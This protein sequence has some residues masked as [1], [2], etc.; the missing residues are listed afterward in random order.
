M[1]WGG[2]QAMTIGGLL[3]GMT[4]PN[5]LSDEWQHPHVLHPPH[6]LPPPSRTKCMRRRLSYC[7]TRWSRK[8]RAVTTARGG[9]GGG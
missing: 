4:L 8:R 3:L 2:G 5:L 7:N 1:R 9:W 6:S